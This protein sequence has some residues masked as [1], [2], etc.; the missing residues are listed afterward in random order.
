[1]LLTGRAWKPRRDT[2]AL[3]LETGTYLDTC[4]SLLVMSAHSSCVTL[5]SHVCIEFHSDR[6]NLLRIEIAMEKV[7]I[8]PLSVFAGHGFGCREGSEWRGSHNVCYPT[9][10][11]PDSYKPP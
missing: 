6:T 2:T 7:E 9:Y 5:G 3:Y 4:L 10:L 8:T 11:I 1:M